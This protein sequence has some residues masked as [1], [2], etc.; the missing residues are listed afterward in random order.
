MEIRLA[1]ADFS[2]P[3]RGSGPRLVPQTLVFARQVNAATA[4]FVGYSIGYSPNDD[5]HVGK[6]EV[7]V[8]TAVSGNTVTVTATLGVRD[9]S[10]DWDD[11]Y[12]GRIDFVVLADLVPVTAPPPRGD[13][14]ITG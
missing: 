2:S 10:G 3:V 5:H 8:D 11:N 1:S 7:K 13:L 9:W 14:Q 4:G 12:Q 6:M